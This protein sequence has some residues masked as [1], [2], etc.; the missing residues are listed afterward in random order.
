MSRIDALI[1]A[2]VADTVRAPQAS[3]RVVAGQSE[4][5]Q[6]RALSDAVRG[7]IPKPVNPDEIR[8]ASLRLKQ[9]IEA[10]SGQQLEFN[11]DEDSRELLVKVMDQKTGEVIRQI[12]SQEILELEKRIHDMI[13]VVLN[14]Q[15]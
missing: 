7:D 9:V 1:A 8:A 14:K 4:H 3:S 5:A 12:P 10:A 15:A 13:G 11:V 2:N 6:I